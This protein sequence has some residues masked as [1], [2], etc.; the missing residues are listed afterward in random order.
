MISPHPKVYQHYRGKHVYLLLTEAIDSAGQ[1]CVVIEW[2][3]TGN[4]EVILY[5]DFVSMV[6]DN[7]EDK[8]KFV[9]IK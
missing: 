7:G 4:K 9:E 6:V 1:N 5:S 3:G 8:R 2:V